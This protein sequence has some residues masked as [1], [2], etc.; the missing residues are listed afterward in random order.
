MNLLAL[1]GKNSQEQ[2]DP[3]YETGFND[4]GMR[5][6]DPSMDYN[7]LMLNPPPYSRGIAGNITSTEDIAPL[8]YDALVNQRQAQNLIDNPDM[9]EWDMDPRRNSI[10]RRNRAKAR[11]EE[12]RLAARERASV[13]RMGAGE[14]SG[15]RQIEMENTRQRAS[16][17]RRASMERASDRRGATLQRLSERQ[18]LGEQRR[19]QRQVE[20]E[21]TRNRASSRRE[22]ARTAAS[23]NRAAAK[24]R[25]L[26]RMP[27]IRE[28]LSSL[29]PRE[30]EQVSAA[31]Q[32][33][34]D[35]WRDNR[36]LF[37]GGREGRLFG[38]ARDWVE[39]RF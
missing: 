24:I 22:L 19:E 2:N 32:A 5:G 12:R 8:D 31:P 17:R 4:P 11:A 30:I 34:R 23:E 1:M 39:D 29:A 13:R 37:Q 35:R 6:S 25:A 18:S 26:S 20:M 16:D 28:D 14:R 21:D 9:D 33:F 10:L 38:R 3:Y 7:S 36:G 27:D 15:Q